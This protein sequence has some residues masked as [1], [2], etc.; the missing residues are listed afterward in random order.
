VIDTPPRRSW[1]PPLAVQI[2]IG[3]VLGIAAGSLFYGNTRF[4]A[5]LQ[6]IGDVFIRLIKMIVVPIVFSTLVVGVSRMGD[7]KRIGALGVKTLI[8]FEIITTIAI[9]FGIAIADLA[10]PGSGLVTA[11]LSKGDVAKYLA[12]AHEAAGHSF[13]D[14]L[15]NVVPTNIGDALARGDMLAIIFFAVFFGL[16]VAV[17]G[18]RGAP[19]SQFFHAVSDAMFWVTNQI[20]RV[21]PAGVFA[22]IGLTA[23]KFGIA[24]FLPLAKLVVVIYVAMFLFVAIVFSIVARLARIR[25]LVLLA[26]VREELLLAFSTASSE[27]VLARIIEKMEAAG[28]PEYVAGIVIPTGYTF[29]LDGSTLYQSIAALFVAQLYGIHLD[30]GAQF[31]LVAT[32]ALASKGM[33]GVPGASLVV[34]LATLGAVGLPVEGLA[35]I[36]G[37]DR[38]LD[39]ARTAVNVCGNSLAAVVMSRTEGV[40]FAAPLGLEKNPTR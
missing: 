38:I 39:M 5:I 6:P 24:S 21:A 2:G 27:S 32:L 13:V 29:N 8:Y 3:L 4:E 1:M 40:V 11:A 16:G 18:E 31:V 20:M 28:C 14:L 23:A 36:A 7:V 34:L 33:A 15:V 9:L 35:F 25:L 37:V 17:L 19:V 10:Q 22:L 12:T 30:L 26:I